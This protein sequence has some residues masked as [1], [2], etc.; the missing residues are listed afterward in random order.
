MKKRIWPAALMLVL[1]TI[2]L[3]TVSFPPAADLPQHLSQIPLLEKA[4]ENPEGPLAVQWTA[5]NTLVYLVIYGLGRALPPE[6]TG[7]ALLAF[8]LVLWVLAGHFLAARKRIPPESAVIASLLVFNQTFYWG[9][10]NFLAGFPVFVAWFVLTTEDGEKDKPGRLVLLA[11]V[12]YLLYASHALWFAAG[13]VWL[14]LAALLKRESLGRLLLR[15]STLVPCAVL[16]L[17]WYP[18][19]AGLRATSGFDVSAHWPA[20]F[21]DRFSLTWFRDAVFGGLHGPTETVA[22]LLIYAWLGL[23]LWRN[24]S[25]IGTAVDRD[26]LAAGLFFVAVAVLGPEKY[27]NTILF[28]SRWL[29]CGTVFLLLAFSPPFPEKRAARRAVYAAAVAFCLITGIIWNRYEKTELSGLRESLDRIAPETRVL[30][31]DL[32]KRS[33][34]IKGRPFLQIFAYAQAFKGSE[35]NFTFAEHGS[36]LVTYRR[37]REIPWT[38]DLE[39]YAELI[40]PT[41]YRHFDYVLVNGAADIQAYFLRI[42]ELER[43]TSS[44]RWQLYAVRKE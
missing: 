19:L 31:L 24:R 17:L 23:S 42:P 1:V 20:S 28:A 2:P 12:S 40:Q 14:G 15:A 25:R 29:P 16:A 9:F 36:G 33:A 27:M 6:L 4:L 35:L 38:R 21:F 7:R 18:R 37:R 26:L 32:E 10:L 11:L 3:L 41:D 34:H 22:F 44:G 30:G 13:A 43:L 39:W 8:L 5:P